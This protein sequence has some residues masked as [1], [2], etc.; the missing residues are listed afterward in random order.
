M[1]ARESESWTVQYLGMMIGKLTMA[2]VRGGDGGGL[3]DYAA[4]ME[5]M[6]PKK[7]DTYLE[8]ALEPMAQYYTNIE[9]KALAARL[10]DTPGSVWN[11]LPWEHAGF[12]DP[13]ESE[14]VKLPA[15]RRLLA[16][17][18]EKKEVIGSLE[19]HSPDMLGYKIGPN[20]GGTR[21]GLKW[22]AAEIP[23]NGTKTELRRCD[24]IGVTLAQKNEIPFFN[25]F[26]SVD[27]RDAAIKNAI[28]S[29]AKSD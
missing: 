12:F 23:P 22:P 4:W 16:R 21:T 27:K 29:L 9:V 19:W 8:P 1:G 17:E 2:R 6:T 26:L 25:P 24:W 20:S 13:I 14:L 28:K 11:S 7:L 3:K 10:F 15:F 5:S 18:M